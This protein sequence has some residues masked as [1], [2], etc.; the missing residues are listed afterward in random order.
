MEIEGEIV[1]EY[2]FHIG[3]PKSATSYLQ[4][5]FFPLLNLTYLGKHYDSKID[6]RGIHKDFENEFK[7][8][9]YKQPFHTIIPQELRQKDF[10]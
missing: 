8:L 9:L 10:C 3:L 1:T 4:K 6:K 7:S 5:N 2:F